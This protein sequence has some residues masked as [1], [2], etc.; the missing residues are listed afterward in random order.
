MPFVNN[1]LLFSM[2]FVSK[3]GV[4]IIQQLTNMIKYKCRNVT[5]YLCAGKFV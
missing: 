2:D 3:R 1:S 5:M 4:V